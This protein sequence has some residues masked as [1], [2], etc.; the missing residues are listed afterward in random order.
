MDR[1]DSLRQEFEAQLL[2]IEGVVGVS[3]FVDEGGRAFLRVLTS[4]PTE[5]V[6]P[7]LP[8]AV[9]ADTILA[10]VGEIEAE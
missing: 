9:R 8:E 6:E 2:R 1:I 3:R 5:Q 7:R 4:V 10:Y